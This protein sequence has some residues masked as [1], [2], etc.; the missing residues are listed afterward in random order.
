ML[1]SCLLC[2]YC[3]NYIQYFNN[4]VSEANEGYACVHAGAVW[5]QKVETPVLLMDTPSLDMAIIVATQE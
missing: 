4:F 2:C 5:M 3:F 1:L